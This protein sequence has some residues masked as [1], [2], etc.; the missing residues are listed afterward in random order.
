VRPPLRVGILA[1][2]EGTTFDGVADAIA[3]EPDR[4]RIVLLL[5]DR[6]GAPVLERA[7]RRGIPAVVV[8]PAG[9]AKNDWADE[10]TTELVAHGADVVVLAGFL[11]I[12]PAP[13]V[14]RWRGRAMNL[15]PSLL[16][17]YGGRGMH[18]RRIHEA[19]LAAGE[20]ETGATL[21]L[22]TLDV[23]GGPAVAQE[24]LSIV[25]G[26]TP[27]T[28]RERLHPVEV[29]LLE[30]TLRRF[31]DGELP[32]PYPGGVDRARDERRVDAGRP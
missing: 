31:A 22:V 21:H 6:A 4:V 19:V 20:R 32:L 24:R 3:S 23:D 11:G 2:G 25:P 10:L 26:D 8:A 9:R 29:G 1:S 30:R 27:D 28:L 14:E 5:S 16:P 18:G 7:R 17:R 15:H 13:W 12:L